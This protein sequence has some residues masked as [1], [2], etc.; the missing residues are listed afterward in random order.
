MHLLADAQASDFLE[1]IDGN[2][3]PVISEALTALLRSADGAHGRPICVDNPHS[4][5]K[6]CRARTSQILSLARTH[7]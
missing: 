5:A 3:A 2:G 1:G 6:V 7:M 4:L